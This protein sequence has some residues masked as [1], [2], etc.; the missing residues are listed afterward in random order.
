MT[1]YVTDLNVEH[2]QLLLF[3]FH[4]LPLMQKKLQL[5]QLAQNIIA[6][7]QTLDN[8]RW[9]EARQLN[10]DSGITDW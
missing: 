3:L 7:A 5:L 8:A 1:P 9:A 4:S 2:A 6:V 10:I